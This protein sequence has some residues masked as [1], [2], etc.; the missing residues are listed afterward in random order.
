MAN[1]STLLPPLYPSL[2]T[3]TTPPLLFSDWLVLPQPS[4]SSRRRYLYLTAFNPIYFI[5]RVHPCAPGA[6]LLLLLRSGSIS[7]RS[8]QGAV[9]SEDSV[10]SLDLS[11]V[12]GVRS[13]GVLELRTANWKLVAA[14]MV[15][16]MVVLAL[17]MVLR[18]RRFLITIV[19]SRSR[20]IQFR[21]TSKEE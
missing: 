21:D 13:S 18:M 6:G 20:R 4:F 17:M 3:S 16:V 1:M 9:V 2:L 14:V 12:G 8:W 15:M 11:T 19:G 10:S 5:A 7:A